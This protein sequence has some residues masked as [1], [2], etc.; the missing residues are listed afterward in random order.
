ME[1]HGG[2]LSI[3]L[4]VNR[5]VP[6]ASLQIFDG[7]SRLFDQKGD[8][9]PERV[10][11]KEFP[12]SDASHKYRFEL[13]NNHGSVLLSQTE[14]EYDWT[15]ASE[16][17]VG[18]QTPYAV[19]EEK[20]RSADDW[21]QLGKN[22][23]LDGE[24]LV[25]GDSYR[26]AL[27][28]FPSSLE[29]HKAAGRLLAGL[30]RYSDAVQHLTTAHERNTTDSETSYYLAICYDALGR[31]REAVD[32]Y[33]EAMRLPSFRP[34]AALR[35]AELY[36]R[37]GSLHAA[38]QALQISLTSAAQ[39]L[40]TAEEL[41][42]VM[43]ALGDN[44]GANKFAAEWFTRFPTSDFLS[45][46]VG[47]P[48]LEHL[49]A[50]PY[51]VLS[52]ATEYARLGLYQRA[53]DILSRQY[54]SVSSDQSEPGTVLPQNNPLILYFRGYCQ[55]KLGASAASDYAKASSLSTLYV[56][57]NTTED[58]NSLTA[59]LRSNRSDATAHFLLGQWH[60]ARGESE[61]AL[62]EWTSARA[63]NPAL[64]AL[65]ASIGL[66]QLHV[67]Q[68]VAA[69]LE[70]F[71]EG[72]KSDPLNVTNYSGAVSAASLLGRT[73]AERVKTLEQY[74][75]LAAMPTALVYELALSRAE[76]EH[77]DGAISLFQNRFFGR[78]EGGTDVRQVWIEVKLSQ[79]L[80]LGR[81]GRCED[82]LAVVKNLAAPA[83]GLVFTDDGLKVPANSGRTN[84]LLGELSAS[85]GQKPEAESR[86]QLSSQ[87]T[88][89]SQIVWAWAAARK[90]PGYNPAQWHDRLNSALSEA[91]SRTNTSSF[92]S[93]WT[94]T[95]G[96]LQIAL[97]RQEQ[98]D[99][100]LRQA[101][102]LPESLMSYHFARLAL[103]G[104]TPR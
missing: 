17:K 85:C 100:A 78:E 25:A 59:A 103:A 57:P 30:R 35:L 75:N 34:P 12:V 69:A 20:N 60:F 79:A 1:R 101:L 10:W 23:E 7:N 74:P 19:P 16:I 39:D 4:N 56:F 83:A 8:L 63:S 32:A 48:R 92:K 24:L 5:K 68:N 18:P 89:P 6:G 44:Q 13:R 36:A 31:E 40:R 87:S 55:E 15:P 77:Y 54:P 91:E 47:K 26:L 62:A 14:G 67:K 50:D 81:A 2:T 86:F 64:P 29:L 82:A 58:F 61:A 99:A 49:A 28:K 72:I 97:G 53:V 27:E 43:H 80:G 52:V 98:G 90:L 70:V 84:Y 71:S 73:P 21:L 46:E 95:T 3:A 9:S 42:A 96:I 76:A 93:W 33:Q 104:T 66:A 22:A 11:K 102:L 38:E 37:Q 45:E 65:D 51:R 94:Y 41:S 88:E